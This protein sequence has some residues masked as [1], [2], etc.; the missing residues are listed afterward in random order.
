MTDDQVRLDLGDAAE[1]DVDR[2]EVV[3]VGVEVAGAAL[4]R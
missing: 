2:L 4:L 3:E 1:A